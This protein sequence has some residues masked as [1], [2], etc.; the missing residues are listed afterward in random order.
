MATTEDVALA[1]REEEVRSAEAQMRLLSPSFSCLCEVTQSHADNDYSTDN[2][3]SDKAELS[4]RTSDSP[5]ATLI[6]RI[7]FTQIHY[8]IEDKKTRLCCGM[9]SQYTHKGR[10][11]AKCYTE[12]K[13]KTF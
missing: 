3:S 2:D 1:T 7:D 11:H 12:E 5:T 9:L 6:C 10:T 8:K 4:R 13:Q